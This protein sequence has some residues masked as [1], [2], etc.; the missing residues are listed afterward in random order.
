MTDETRSLTAQP[1]P[2][3]AKVP[4]VGGHGITAIIPQDVE[5]AFRMASLIHRA[6]MAPKDMNTPEKIVVAILH[7]AEIGLPP[8][9]AI[10]SIAVINGRPTVWGDG[11]MA[12]VRASGLLDDFDE[13]IVGTGD[14]RR[15]ICV[16]A[17]RGQA[18]PIR[19]EFSVADAKEAGLWGKSVWKQYPSRM[20]QM[21][22]RSWVLRDGFADV[23][24]GITIT[25]EILDHELRT[26]PPR[27]YEDEILGA[28][29]EDAPPI[30][31]RVEKVARDVATMGPERLSQHFAQMPPEQVE[32]LEPIKAEL[33]A[34]AAGEHGA[35]Q[36][37]K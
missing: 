17:R 25:E 28:H 5:Q 26:I 30:D 21:R 35:G 16:A 31:P 22:A 33:E 11:A 27:P 4:L 32:M 19:H 13:Q 34:I 1:E 14:A 18:T 9:Q 7:G 37:S 24:R 29:E 6:G 20:L 8:M 36:E 12:L 10:Q 23:L 2:E 15:A 3:K